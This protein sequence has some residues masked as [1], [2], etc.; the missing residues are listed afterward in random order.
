M[1]VSLQNIDKVNALLTVKLEKA[2]YQTQV[3]KSLKKFRQQAKV[4]GFRPGMVPMGLVQKMYG[5]SVKAEEVNKVLSDKIY[6]YIKEQDLKVLGE[7]LPNEE[8]QA[9]LDFDTQDDFEFVFDLALAPEFKAEV[10]KKDKID[11]Y[12][13]EVTDDMIT[14]QIDTYRQ[15]AGKYDKVD[16]YQ[17]KDMLKGQL[18]EQGVEGGISIEG[19]VIMPAYFKAEDQK[20]LFN[21]AKVGDVITFNPYKAYE[22]AEP[23]LSNMLKIEKEAVKDHQGDFTLQLEEIT[24][25]NMADLSQEIYDQVYDAGTVKTEEEFRAKVK[26]SLAEQ[27]VNDSNYKFSVDARDYILQKVGKIEF[28]DALLKKMMKINN[29]DKDDK[30]IE[31]NYEES[32]KGLTWT[33]AKEQFMTTYGIEIKNEDIEAV[34][35]EVTRA[36]FAQYG[37]LNVPDELLNNY[38]Q[39]M[40]KKQDQAQNLFYRAQEEKLSVALKDKVTLNEKPITID[41]FNKLFDQQ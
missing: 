17:D 10:S 38:V 21:E 25:F 26:E 14:R 22:G 7:P 2:D 36:Q 13:I 8:K 30:F 40:L 9:K 41:E 33:M 27:F 31:E 15:R 16:V 4:P 11:Y 28:P 18:T 23:Q 12:N 1:N 34:A 24:R 5:K 20:A 35:R 39:E 32:I 29:P 3:E 37:M 6:S 19:C